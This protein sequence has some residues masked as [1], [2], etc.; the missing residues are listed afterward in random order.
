VQISTMSAS[1]SGISVG[2]AVLFW[3]AGGDGKTFERTCAVHGMTL[4]ATGHL[5]IHV[6]R[7]YTNEEI[8]DSFQ[9]MKMAL[10]TAVAEIFAAESDNVKGDRKVTVTIRSNSQTTIERSNVSKSLPLLH[11]SK[12]YE[13]SSPDGSSVLYDSVQASQSILCTGYLDTKRW[14]IKPSHIDH[15]G[16]ELVLKCSNWSVRS[17]NASMIQH[18]LQSVREHI[19]NSVRH[20]GARPDPRESIL[21]IACSFP[22]FAFIIGLPTAS[23][24]WFE[25]SGTWEAIYPQPV[26]L[27]PILGKNWFSIRKADEGGMIVVQEKVTMQYCHKIAGKMQVTLSKVLLCGVEDSAPFTFSALNPAPTG[28]Q[29]RQ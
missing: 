2:D 26:D 14:T 25:Q 12:M 21:T 15:Q 10:P 8:V 16:M 20:L 9:K 5:R 7:L 28:F 3:E 11:S 18:M 23:L 13:N 19:F 17:A 22:L 6:T 27:E 1:N 24:R 4:S 29:R